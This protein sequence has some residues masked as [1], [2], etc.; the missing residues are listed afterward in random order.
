MYSMHQL[1]SVEAI[2]RRHPTIHVMPAHAYELMID[3]TSQQLAVR[4]FLAL[5]GL[6]ATPSWLSSESTGPHI[7]AKY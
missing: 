5:N 3:T 4:R 2:M 1:L 6:P 7:P